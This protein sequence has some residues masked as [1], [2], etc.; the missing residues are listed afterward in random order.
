MAK[1]RVVDDLVSRPG[2]RLPQPT[3][4]FA[5]R[6]SR[7]WLF[8]VAI[9]FGVQPIVLDHIAAVPVQEG[10]EPPEP[11]CQATWLAGHQQDVP[12]AVDVR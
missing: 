9:E 4:V 1:G 3:H 5:D 2:Q 6:V 12:S 8:H 10:E 11:R 7:H